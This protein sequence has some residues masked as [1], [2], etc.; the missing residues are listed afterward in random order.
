MEVLSLIRRTALVTVVT[1]NDPSA[2]SM[3]DGL[4][5]QPKPHEKRLTTLELDR[6]SLV[7]FL[8]GKQLARNPIP[9]DTCCIFHLP[10]DLPH[11]IS[12]TKKAQR[13]I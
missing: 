2:P 5:N 4:H 8:R 12:Q 9:Y 7:W 11:R 13:R 10:C 3:I 1:H 6:D